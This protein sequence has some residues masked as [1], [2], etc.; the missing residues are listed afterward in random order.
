MCVYMDVCVYS[1]VCM[2]YYRRIWSCLIACDQGTRQ[3]QVAL[4]VTE[5]P[6]LK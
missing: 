3:L 4:V 1:Q 2:L 5:V 6:R